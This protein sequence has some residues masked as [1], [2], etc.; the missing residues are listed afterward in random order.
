LEQDL[1]LGYQ[2]MNQTDAGLYVSANL[3]RRAQHQQAAIRST[4]LAGAEMS[5]R[6]T[7]NQVGNELASINKKTLKMIF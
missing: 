3:Q 1:M 5:P 2:Q 6:Q 4:E 7:S